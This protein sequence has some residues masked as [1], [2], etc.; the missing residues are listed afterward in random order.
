MCIPAGVDRTHE[1]QNRVM[2][3]T[4]NWAFF[5]FYVFF[6]ARELLARNKSSRAPICMTRR[7]NQLG[8]CILPAKKSGHVNCQSLGT[9]FTCTRVRHGPPCPTQNSCYSSGCQPTTDG[10]PCA[11]AATTSDKP[12]SRSLS[13]TVSS[14]KPH[15]R[16]ASHTAIAPPKITGARF[17]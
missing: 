12:N 3:P 2:M 15:A 17:G 14:V 10:R 6:G 7:A 1:H 11:V 16:N 9:P 13:L 5:T 8:F 4:A